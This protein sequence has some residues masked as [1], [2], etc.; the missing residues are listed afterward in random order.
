VALVGLCLA[1]A[2]SPVALTLWPHPGRAARV[3]AAVRA[4]FPGFC[5]EWRDTLVV[6]PNRFA[7]PTVWDVTC[8]GGLTA[9]RVTAMS[10]NVATCEARPPLVATPDWRRVYRALFGA[11]HRMGVCP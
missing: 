1:S 4:S 7:A 5:S 9:G 3:E 11:G 2:L 10:V 8:I 6:T